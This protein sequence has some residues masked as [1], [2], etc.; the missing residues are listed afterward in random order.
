MAG[1]SVDNFTCLTFI[2]IDKVFN[3][4]LRHAYGRPVIIIFL[5]TYIAP[6]LRK[7]P[8]LLPDVGGRQGKGILPNKGA[9]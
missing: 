3:G 4:M 6:V 9:A 7:I 8:V 2:S 5:Q 1:Q